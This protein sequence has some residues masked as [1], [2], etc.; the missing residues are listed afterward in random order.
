[1]KV[2]I[3]EFTIPFKYLTFRPKYLKQKMGEVPEP[4][5]IANLLSY[6]LIIALLYLFYYSLN[7]RKELLQRQKNMA[8]TQK[9]PTTN[10]QK[11]APPLNPKHIF[12]IEPSPIQGQKIPFPSIHN[13]EEVTLSVVIPVNNLQHLILNMLEVIQIYF[14][15]KQAS[16]P[17]FTYEVIIVDCMSTDETYSIAYDFALQN[18]EFRIC[19]IPFNVS[20]NTAILIGCIRTRGKF[21]YLYLQHERIPIEEYERFEKKLYSGLKYQRSVAVFGCYDKSFEEGKYYRTLLSLFLEYL[22]SKFSLF[23]DIKD[24]LHHHFGTML[25]TREAGRILFPNMRIPGVG[26]DEE[27]LVIADVTNV[28]IKRAHLPMENR[29]LLTASSVDQLDILFTLIQSLL[30]YKTGLWK[31]SR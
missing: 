8:N 21:I 27:L 6:L 16:T 17:D 30:A 4:P 18:P 15:K 22:T 3:I 23:L 20:F 13:P 28:L 31:I 9:K 11:N 24:D 10:A 2:K 1:M 12:Y 5:F 14:S 29:A 7:L 25:V 26:F 19:Q